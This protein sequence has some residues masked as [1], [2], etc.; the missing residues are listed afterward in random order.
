MDEMKRWMVIVRDKTSTVS[1]LDRVKAVLTKCGK[2]NL[3]FN[4]EKVVF[5][6][7]HVRSNL[8]AGQIR[9]RLDEVVSVGN[10]GFIYVVELGD[11]WAASGYSAAW[12]HF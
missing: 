12:R 1:I 8:V 2:T 4:D 7:F 11:D 10:G 3:M 9:A 5:C 6:A